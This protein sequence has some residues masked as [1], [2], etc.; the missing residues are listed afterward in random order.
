MMRIVGC[1][2]REERQKHVRIILIGNLQGWN[3]MGSRGS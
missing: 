2:I 3:G 1:A